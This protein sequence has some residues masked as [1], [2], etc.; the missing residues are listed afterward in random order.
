MTPS[1]SLLRLFALGSALLFGT[2]C[3]HIHVH[4]KENPVVD[5]MDYKQS[6]DSISSQQELLYDGIYEQI[7]VARKHENRKPDLAIAI[8]LQVAETVWKSKEDGFIPL[9]NHAVGQAADLIQQRG[10]RNNGIYQTSSN[11]YQVQF[12]SSQ[13]ATFSES[14]FDDLVPVDCLERRG[15]RSEVS[16]AGLGASLVVLHGTDEGNGVKENPFVSPIGGD[17]NTT[18]I[19]DFSKKGKAVFRFYDV[20][21][22]NSVQFWGREQDMSVNLTAGYYMLAKRKSEGGGASRIMGVFRPMRYSGRMGLYLESRFDPDKIPLIL[23]HGLV[24]SPIT[25]VDPMNEVLA[26]PKIRANYQS[27][28]YYYPTGFPVRMTGAKLKEDLL[29]LEA[30]ARSQGAGANVDKTVIFGHSMGGLLTS[31]NVRELD[32][33]TWAKVSNKSI[34]DLPFSESMKEDFTTI[35]VKPQPSGIKR[36]VFI[37]TPH[38]GSNKA[39]TWYGGFVTTL[40]KIPNSLVNFDIVGAAQSMTDLGKSIFN[41]DGPVNSMVTLRTGNPAL[42]MVADRPIFPRVPY[43]SIIGDRGKGDT[44]DS[45]DGVVPYASSH[46]EGAESELIVPSGHSAHRDPAAVKE[47]QRILLEHLKEN[48]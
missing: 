36:A 30:Y 46:L 22:V 47:M 43:H 27:Y 5:L 26:D 8:Y 24:S 29:R 33:T 31:M 45:S 39:N 3:S 20:T 17:F 40:I 14:G 48:S 15:L 32:E 44:P 34:D 18:L 37:S 23:V 6:I 1:S 19:V 13:P 21:K 2:Q 4:E 10:L 12:D 11:S 35:F 42:E 9:Y 38:H 7:I 16:Q 25:W 41:Q 28:T